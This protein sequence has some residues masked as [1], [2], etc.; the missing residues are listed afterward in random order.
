MSDTKISKRQKLIS[1]IKKEKLITK[2]LSKLSMKEL[3]DFDKNGLHSSDW[4]GTLDDKT[5]Y[6]KR[7]K[8]L[9]LITKKKLLKIVSAT[10]IKNYSHLKHKDLINLIAEKYWGNF[11]DRW[12]EAARGDKTLLPDWYYGSDKIRKIGRTKK[13][14]PKKRG[15]QR[16][17]PKKPE[18][19]D[20]TLRGK[21]IQPEIATEQEIKEDKET[22]ENFLEN[23]KKFAS[24]EP[25]EYETSTLFKPFLLLSVLKRS[26]NDCS[27]RGDLRIVATNKQIKKVSDEEIKE[28]TNAYLRCKK[29][30]KMLV[31]PFS[32]P[33]HSNIIIFNFHRKEIERFEPHGKQTGSRKIDSGKINKSLDKDLVKKINS[34]LPYDEQLKFI[35]SNE[36]CPTGFQGFQ[37]Y[38]GQA[39]KKSGRN[40]VFLKDPKG[41][42][43]AWSYFY[44]FLRLKFPKQSASDLIEDTYKILKTDPEQLRSFIRG[45]VKDAFSMFKEALKDYYIETKKLGEVP[46]SSRTQKGHELIRKTNELYE[47]TKNKLKIYIDEAFKK[48]TSEIPEKKPE[49][50]KE[51]PEPEEKKDD[52]APKNTPMTTAE[53]NKKLQEILS[54]KAM[55]KSKLRKVLTELFSSMRGN[56]I[57]YKKNKE[58]IDKLTSPEFRKR[59]DFN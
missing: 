55:P 21:V 6:E 9:S 4:L 52:E 42:C 54:S 16:Q 38:E 40:N 34:R 47:D 43:V 7:Q 12:Q 45:Q 18:R 32:L 15:P 25:V 48:Y 19:L 3:K 37:G 5:A 11:H 23:Q 59:M 30:K 26:K 46:K 10:R 41:F 36:V 39:N 51:E 24:K 2:G 27:A 31:L 49:E 44:A 20:R 33:G 13:P 8:I 35:P 53:G 50:K 58:I 56:P 28:I 17:A 14:K 57:F 22:L 1:K 29:R